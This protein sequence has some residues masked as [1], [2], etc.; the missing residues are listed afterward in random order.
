MEIKGINGFEK[1][2]VP[3]TGMAFQ[4]IAS[5]FP[6]QHTIKWNHM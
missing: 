3:E 5:D 2:S 6:D 1:E 4:N